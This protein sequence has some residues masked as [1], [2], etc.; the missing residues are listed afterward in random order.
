MTQSPSVADLTESEFESEADP[1]VI[2][3]TDGEVDD[4]FSALSSATAREILQ[5]LRDAPTHPAAL[6]QE[7]DTSIQNVHYHLSK[8]TD[9]GVVRVIGTTLSEKGREMN[10]YAPTA[11]PLVLVSGNEDD[12]D[13][14]VE[15]L[16]KFLAGVGTVSLL[17]VLV[18]KFIEAVFYPGGPKLVTSGT[19][20]YAAPPLT[21]VAPPIGLYA[22]IVGLGCLVVWLARRQ[23]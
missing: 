19:G 2:D 15:S 18:Q 23:M 8:L 13:E 6:S 12:Q 11:E 9:A 4:L 3:F 7:I 5:Q 17:S 20:Q 16:S 1:R 22:F 14:L 10:I 21:N